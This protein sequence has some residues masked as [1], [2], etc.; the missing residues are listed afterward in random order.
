MPVGRWVKRTADATFCTFWPPGPAGPKG[1]HPDVL[2]LTSTSSSTLCGG[3]HLYHGE[4]SV[5]QVVGVEG[6]QPHQ[7]VH[8]PFGRQI[9]EGV[10]APLPR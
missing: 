1:V 9:T 6:R 3:Q 2:G 8:P 5:P 4:G 10:I 7:A